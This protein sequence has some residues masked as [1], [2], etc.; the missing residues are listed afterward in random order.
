MTNPNNEKG[1]YQTEVKSLMTQLES[2]LPAD[3]FA[4]FN[5]DAQQFAK[6][7]PRPLKVGVG[8]KAAEFA[9][10]NPQG[11]MIVLSKLLLNGPVVLT[12]YRGVWCPYCNLELRLYQA[13]LAQIQAVGGSLVAVSPMTPDNSLSMQE[14]NALQFHVLS[15]TQ[16]QIARHYTTV[17]KNSASSIQ[18]M[19][20]L[21]YDFHGFY[22]DDSGEIPIPAT[23]VI[24]QQGV[25]TFAQSA[26]GDYRQRVE[27][28]S[29]LDALTQK[30]A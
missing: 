6:D 25:I 28:Q 7:Y 15:D 12:F 10:P 1:R 18:A 24:D 9:L 21:G 8:D 23:F 16:N 14:Q 30:A 2:M 5:Q 17:F 22:A 11:E 27:P 20:D 26:G 29:I 19:A 13:I 3:K 4:V